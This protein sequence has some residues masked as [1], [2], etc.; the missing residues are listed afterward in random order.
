MKSYQHLAA[1]QLAD[2]TALQVSPKFYVIALSGEG[3]LNICR[4]SF[5]AGFP[6]TANGR[7]AYLDIDEGDYVSMYFNGRLW[8]LYSV[9]RKFI[10]PEYV[11][12]LAKGT[13]AEDLVAV[14]SG[15][16]WT[17]IGSE[18]KIY[19]PY[20]LELARLEETQF[21]TNLVFS[22]GLER[23][24][25]NLI[26]RVSLKKT[27]FQLSLNDLYKIFHHGGDM[28]YKQVSFTSFIETTNRQFV[29]K[30]HQPGMPESGVTVNDVTQQECYL[31]ALLK[32]IFEMSWG[33][34]AP[35]L[36][37]PNASVEFL[38][39]QTV[40]GGEA[41]IVVVSG[42]EKGQELL[43]EI[44]NDRIIN[45]GRLTSIGERAVNQVNGYQSLLRGH[46]STTRGIAGKA[47]RR[48]G[49]LLL[50]KFDD[51]VAIEID[52]ALPISSLLTYPA[53]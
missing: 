21:E 8:D 52:S 5:T 32:K 41:D 9:E 40:H 7:W 22:A 17:S 23:L 6:D 50:A 19:F 33:E 15:E 37:F 13:H 1:I 53:A 28:K 26:P 12:R 20:R 46:S 4:S 24:G 39:E 38:S 10:P 3:N 31:Q 42:G 43:I 11:G 30:A 47:N 44:K 29:I 18:P 25:I 35:A 51:V 2:T 27:H 45:R 14:R 34:I 16:R 36:N 48:D 49:T